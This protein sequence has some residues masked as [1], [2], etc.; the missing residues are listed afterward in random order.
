ML[1][2]VVAQGDGAESQVTYKPTTMIRL[3]SQPRRRGEQ[4][5][6]A[7]VA[8][9]IR[10]YLRALEVGRGA[11]IADELLRP[12]RNPRDITTE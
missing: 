11:T 10:A 2:T 4:R 9:L 6:N 1:S 12:A 5:S 8:D 7:N 3:A